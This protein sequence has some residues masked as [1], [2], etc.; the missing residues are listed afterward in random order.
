[1]Y[2]YIIIAG[3][4]L[5]SQLANVGQSHCKKGKKNYRRYVYRQR[6]NLTISSIKRTARV[7]KTFYNIVNNREKDGI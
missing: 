5:Q 1:M 2:S 6:E 7:E 4:V 3:S